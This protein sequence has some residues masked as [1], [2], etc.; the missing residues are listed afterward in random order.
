M[1]IGGDTI[2]DEER[3]HAKIATAYLTDLDAL[4]KAIEEI[5]TEEIILRIRNRK[6]ELVKEL[7]Y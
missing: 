1:E 5:C 7:K 6:T 4:E 2:I 3:L